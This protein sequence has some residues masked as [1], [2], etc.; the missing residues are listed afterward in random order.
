M[1]TIPAIET[2]N[3]ECAFATPTSTDALLAAR[4][5]LAIA[6]SWAT[7]GFRRLQIS[8][9]D[10]GFSGRKHAGVVEE[11]VRDGMVSVQAVVN[12]QSTEAVERLVDAGADRLVLHASA[13]DDPSW[14]ETLAHAYPSSVLVATDVRERRTV[15]RGWVRSVPVDIFDLIGDL[16]GLPLAGL[17]I[18][19]ANGNGSAS[20]AELAL[21]E[22]LAETSGFPVL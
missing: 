6:R 22:D 1:I 18:S 14:I 10:L 8:D 21:L 5:P 9:S 19:V 17:L 11:I 16:E 7:T 12:G 4:T 13:V 20:T 3:G 15:T 2:R